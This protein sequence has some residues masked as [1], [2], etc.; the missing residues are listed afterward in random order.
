MNKLRKLKWLYERWKVMEHPREELHRLNEILQSNILDRIHALNPKIPDTLKFI[1]P[2]IHHYKKNDLKQIFGDDPDITT[3]R[4]FDLTV[5]NILE[6]HSWSTD[7]KNGID[8]G[9]LQPRAKYSIQDFKRFGEIKY[10]YELARLHY[11]PILAALAFATNDSKLQKTI[12]RHIEGFAAQNPYLNSINWVNGIEVGIRSVNLVLTRIFCAG[13]ADDRTL[14]LLDKQMYLHAHFLRSHL[15]LY[16]SATNHLIAELCGLYTICSVLDFNNSNRWRK[17]ALRR[18]VSEMDNQFSTD[19]YS[20]ERSVH[21][22]TEVINYYLVLLM[23]LDTGHDAERELITDRVT[24]M[25]DILEHFYQNHEHVHLFGDSDDGQLIYPYNDGAFDPYESLLTDR[26]S[27]PGAPPA[28]TRRPRFDLRNYILWGP[29]GYENFKNLSRKP[30]PVRRLGSKYFKAAGLL[31]LRDDYAE[32]IFDCGPFGKKPL[33]AHAHCDAL[34]FTFSLLNS[35]VIVD[36]GTYQYHPRYQ[37][38]R[39]YFTGTAGHN[40]IQIDGLEQA[41]RS[42]R[43]LWTKTPDVV[44]HRYEKRRGFTECAASHDGFVKQGANAVHKRTI[45]H[46]TEKHNFSIV[47][48]IN[49]SGK[50]SCSLFLHF[51]SNVDDIQLSGPRLT[52]NVEG[53]TLNIVNR[54]FDCAVLVRGTEDPPF[55]WYSPSFNVKLPSWS[56]RLDTTYED[57]LRLSTLIDYSDCFRD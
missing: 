10:V 20:A 43:M 29:E 31:F 12:A 2:R 47:D 21:Y 53:G 37:T 22:H 14:L 48:Q 57:H 50:H 49:G 1:A 56:L 13:S 28:G 44:V 9:V 40:T 7:Y 19:C 6:I 5:D 4:L 16:S 41:R 35:P 33:F 23:F 39:N 42:G 18:L 55:G 38:W 15:S 32:L 45:T 25:I 51:H 3:Y 52:I 27:L 36:I 11:L 34:S 24:S 30:Q 8:A 54:L 26:T 46:S 17:F